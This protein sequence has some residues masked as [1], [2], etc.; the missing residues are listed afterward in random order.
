MPV[1]NA[2]IASQLDK[3]ADLLDIEGANPFRVR[4]YRRAARLVG[5]LPRSV[6]DMLAEG[7]DLDELPGIGKDLAD[8]IATIARGGHLPLLDELSREVP[9]GITVL[10]ALPGLGPKRVHLL[11]E[12]LGIDTIDKLAVATKAGKLRSIPGFGPGIEA[13][14]LRAIAEGAGQT[15]RTKLAT[16]E[17]IA[18]PLL[19]HLRQADGV[20]QAEVAGSYRR[21]RETVGDLD[22]VVAAQP[23]QP[24][25]QR[26]TGYED[27]TEIVEQGPT[28]ATIR[29]RNGLQVDLRV[30]PEESFGA[31]LCYFTGSK[32]HNIALRQI[33]VDHGQKLNEYGLFEGTRRLAGRSEAELYQHLGLPI[34]PPELREDQGEID[35]ARQGKLPRLVTVDDIRGDLHAH[36]T[37]SD[38]RASLWDMAQA[39]QAKGYSYIA[40]T[41]HSHRVAIAHG[42]DAKRLARQID[43]IDRTN[44]GLSGFVVLKSIEVDILEDG[45]LDLPDQILRRLDLVIGA[46]HS[47][48]DLP[49]DKQTERILRAMDNRHLNI[50]AHPTGRLINERPAYAI[51]MEQV[52]RGAVARGC[53]LE[54]NA[55]PDRLDLTDIHCRLAKELGLKVAISTDAHATIEFDFMRFGV[56]QARRGWLEPDDVLNTR[57]IGELRDM[58]RRRR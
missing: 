35:A 29:L 58:L 13:R 28:R 50:L 57:L 2:E 8:K 22:I 48:F 38:G 53:Y 54:L 21:R 17:Q 44:D 43:E 36:T 10:L 24:V 16:A 14:V 25:M 52:M 47:R 31:A 34:I 32:P 46:I 19:R 23:S 5:E 6:A 27:V 9:A 3:I 15:Q 4:A 56:D 26:F 42:L 51:D 40:I 20:L 18:V 1:A 45:S 33:A 49:Q 12:M 37:A 30:V 7:Q 55:Q 41:D 11:H 39:A